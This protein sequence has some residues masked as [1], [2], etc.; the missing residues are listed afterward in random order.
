[1]L[2]NHRTELEMP[3]PINCDQCGALATTHAIQY[4]YKPRVV[5][6]GQIDNEL[7]AIVSV[8]EC[9]NC[10]MRTQTAEAARDDED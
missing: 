8:V 4:I 10:G 7:R 6:G 2:A 5:D 1:M 3:Q 9:P